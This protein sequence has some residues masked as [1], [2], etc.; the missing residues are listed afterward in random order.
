SFPQRQILKRRRTQGVQ[1][2]QRIRMNTESNFHFELNLEDSLR[3][4]PWLIPF[5]SLGTGALLFTGIIICLNYFNKGIY[6]TIIPAG[7]LAH[8]FFIVIVHDGA[9]KSITRTKADRL[10]MNL[11]SAMMLLPFYGEPFRKFHLIHHGNTNTE[12]D[13]LWPPSK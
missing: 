9:H 13:P 3:K 11:G 8:A 4:L 2:P 7:L 5:I 1:L 6:W 12:V 10:I